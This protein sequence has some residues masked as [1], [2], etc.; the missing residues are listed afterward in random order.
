MGIIRK[1]K[2]VKLIASIIANKEKLFY[3]IEKELS[4]IFGVIDFSSKILPFNH[5]DYYNKEMGD[6]LIRKFISFEK[7]ILPD[8]ISQI[9]IKSNEIEKKFAINNYRQVNIDPGYINLAKLVL[10][11]TKDY[12]HRIY[13]SNGIYAEATLFFRHNQ[14]ETFPYTYPDYA[15]DEVRN[16]LKEIRKLF[17]SQLKNG[18]QKVK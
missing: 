17:K 1:V 18:N 10:V 7:L 5:T 13:L 16:I 4:E 2:P 8:Q 6:N 9:K 11:S 12:S 14:F 3:E 15:T